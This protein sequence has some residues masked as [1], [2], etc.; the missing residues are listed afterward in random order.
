LKAKAEDIKFKE[1]IKKLKDE[2]G[3]KSSDSEGG[4]QLL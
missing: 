4:S 2:E 3:E 1:N